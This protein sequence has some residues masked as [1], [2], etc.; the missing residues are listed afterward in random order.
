MQRLHDVRGP[1]GDTHVQ[2]TS[3]GTADIK[4]I[5]APKDA[6]ACL[7]DVATTDARVT[8]D[9]SAPSAT[10]GLIVK[11]GQQ[12]IY[13]GVGKAVMFASTAAAAS[14]VDLLWLK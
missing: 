7:I 9:G 13:V 4:T 12:P 2:A 3:A 10:N 11:A 6:V 14:I 1:A 5:A 8:F